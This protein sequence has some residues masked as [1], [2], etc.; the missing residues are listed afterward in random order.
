MAAVNPQGMTEARRIEMLRLLE[1]RKGEVM[2]DR[3]HAKIVL[4]RLERELI[5]IEDAMQDLQND[6][7][8]T[9]E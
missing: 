9:I 2:Y 7:K 1:Q 3:S 8:G 4:Q 6:A 5:E